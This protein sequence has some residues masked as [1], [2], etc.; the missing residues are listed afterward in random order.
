MGDSSSRSRNATPLP[1]PSLKDDNNDDD[2]DDIEDDDIDEDEVPLS[3]L[4]EQVKAE[5]RL[6]MEGKL[7]STT[8]STSTSNRKEDKDKDE[9]IVGANS[10]KNKDGDGG[11]VVR[12][13]IL[14]SI[15]ETSKRTETTCST[16]E[17]YYY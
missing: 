7:T 4:I 8:T 1:P 10:N 5:R 6:S 13:T 16:A 3:K 15:V 11:G 9:T 12:D 2:G 14:D 17:S